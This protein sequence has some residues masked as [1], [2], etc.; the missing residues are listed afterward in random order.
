MATRLWTKNCCALWG[1]VLLT[2]S[3]A[4]TPPSHTELAPRP[5]AAAPSSLDEI[6]RALVSA[7]LQTSPDIRAY[8]LGPED[9]IRITIFNIP[10][11]EGAKGVTP[12]TMDARVSHQG[13][14]TLPLLGE[15]PVQG[16]TILEVEQKLHG[17][18]EKYIHSPEIGVLVTEYRSQRVAVVGAVVSPGV[19]ELTGPK[20]LLD[21]L[22]MAKGLNNNASSQV[23]LY[24]QMP[25]G[26]T[27]YVI[28]LFT[29]TRGVG[30]DLAVLT[31]LVQA[32]DVISIPE[33]G[34]FFVDGAVRN[35]G[36]YPLHRSY[37]VSQALI[38]AGGVDRELAK[39]SDITLY[40]HRGAAETESI[41]LDLNE[42]ISGK[43]PDPQIAAEDVIVV[44][45]S[46][47]KWIV[48]R[49]LGVLVSGVS[50]DRFLIP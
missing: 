47:P 29:L 41:P 5:D 33:A 11:E 31:L 8:R 10:Q 30:N 40:R 45:M 44:P 23:H 17:L 18:Y 34:T 13:N 42:I 43:A 16:L 35:P 3:C 14:I 39:T 15:I 12:R 46:T 28:D 27:S 19:F 25:E 2:T 7:A 37:T 6:N 32:G 9:M 50:I 21:L 1:I 4:A 48:R 49:F 24:R 26:R 22:A 38:T 20:T 36:S